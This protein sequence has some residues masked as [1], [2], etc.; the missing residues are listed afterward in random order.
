MPPRAEIHE[1]GKQW[2]SWFHRMKG[3]KTRHWFWLWENKAFGSKQSCW[4]ST[5][6]RPVE[7]RQHQVGEELIWVKSPWEFQHS[8]D[9][10]ISPGDEAQGISS[11]LNTGGGQGPRFSFFPWASSL[12]CATFL[13]KQVS[14]HRPMSQHGTPG[15]RNYHFCFWCL[16]GQGSP[17]EV[18]SKCAW[19]NA[20]KCLW[21]NEHARLPTKSLLQY[22]PQIVL[23]EIKYKEWTD[24]GIR[25]TWLES[26]CVSLAKHLLLSK[27]LFPYLMHSR[28]STWKGG[29]EEWKSVKQ[30]T[31]F[32]RAQQR[33]PVVLTGPATTC[34]IDFY[35]LSVSICWSCRLPV[36]NFL[37]HIPGGN[38]SSGLPQW[39]WADCFPG[40]H[41]G[42]SSSSSFSDPSCWWEASPQEPGFE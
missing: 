4:E 1:R 19:T 42:N 38:Y 40:L 13:R 41:F 29:H 25:H 37:A 27:S 9:V 36:G 18:L 30:L 12:L 11:S 2:S 6:L 31:L 28:T 10:K 5:P 17:Q 21:I 33:A 23:R 39:P 24:F 35:W 8:T 3:S 34:R 15:C 16:W 32:L 14:R 22:M 20:Q 7:A 26:S